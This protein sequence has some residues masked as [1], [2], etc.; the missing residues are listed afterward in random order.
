MDSVFVVVDRFSKMINFIPY[1]TTHDAIHIA[2][3][4]F[5][6]VVK[7]HGL[8]MSIVADRDVK[9]MGNFWKTLGKRLE[10]IWLMVFPTI[11]K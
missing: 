4:F 2:N 5:K 10:L 11:P 9:F 3:L 1:K 7:I 6:E 8:P